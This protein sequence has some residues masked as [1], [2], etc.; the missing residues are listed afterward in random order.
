MLST[1]QHG[2]GLEAR[3]E[4]TCVEGVRTRNSRPGDN[5]KL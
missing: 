1:Q 5:S 2:S 4:G 3:R